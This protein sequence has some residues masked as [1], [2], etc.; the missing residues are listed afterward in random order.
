MTKK[1]KVLREFVSRKLNKMMNEFK[2]STH[3]NLLQ[4][5]QFDFK[6]TYD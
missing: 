5:D 2:P 4:P 1:R 3:S 6:I